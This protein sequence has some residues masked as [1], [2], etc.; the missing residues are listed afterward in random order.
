[1]SLCDSSLLCPWDSP[2]KIT[3]VGCH[4]VLLTQGSNP[5]LLH[6]RQILYCLSYQGNHKCLFSSVQFSRSVVSASLSIK[7]QQIL[8]CVPVNAI[9][10]GLLI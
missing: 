6:C 3:G 9:V 1:M 2:G 8:I 10:C 4:S 5:G 7:D